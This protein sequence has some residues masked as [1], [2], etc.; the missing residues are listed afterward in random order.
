MKLRNF[1]YNLVEY[2]N[3]FN[4]LEAKDAVKIYSIKINL[5]VNVKNIREIQ[6]YERVLGSK[7]VPKGMLEF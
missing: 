1:V 6:K 4:N 2:K 5:Y 7:Y 3:I